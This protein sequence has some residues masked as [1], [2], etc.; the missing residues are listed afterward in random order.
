MYDICCIGHITLDKVVTPFS[1]VEM[2]GGTAFYFS[3][4]LHN[5]DRNFL[6]LTAVGQEEKGFVEDL[7]RKGIDVISQPSSHTVNFVNIYPADQDIRVQKVLQKAEP[8]HFDETLAGIEASIYHLGSLL[9]DDFSVE[10]IREVAQKGMVSLDVQGLLRDVKGTDVVAVDWA[11]KAAGLA[12]IDI[13]KANETEMA[14]LSG[15]ADIRQGA[16]ILAD[17]GVR[18]VVIT[19]GSKGSVIYHDD[20]FTLIPAFVPVSATLDA[21]GCGDTYMAGYLYKKAKGSSIE[22]AAIFGAAMATLNMETVG[23]FMGKEKEVLD[24]MATATRKYP[25]L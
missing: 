23:P 7:E 12:Y 18:E 15:T 1:E 20:V 16:R 17:Y 4:A 14:V 19:L 11:Q 13:L 8:F 24:K 3:N 2:P 21:T 6:L 9:A 25:G 22:E 10:F 5:I